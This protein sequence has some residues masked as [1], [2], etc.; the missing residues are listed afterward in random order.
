MQMFKNEGTFTPDSLIVSPD[1]PIL[2][3]GIGLKAGQGVLKRGTVI[4]KGTDGKGYIAGGT[5]TVTTGEGDTAT[6]SEMEL[7]AFGILTDNM[8]TGDATAT[9]DVPAVVYTTGI[10]NRGVLIVADGAEIATFEDALKGIGIH[11]RDVQ[12]Y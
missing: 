7:K 4:C 8:D 1:F 10:F 2:K 3:D 11:L 9:D 5:V 6:T 12:N